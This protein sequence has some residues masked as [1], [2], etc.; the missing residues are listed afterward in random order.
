MAE[1]GVLNEEA[2]GA[3]G[4]RRYVARDDGRGGG[5]WYPDPMGAW[6]ELSIAE[7][8]RGGPSGVAG[9]PFGSSLGRKHYVPAGVPVIRGAQ[10]GG[11]GRFS[12]DGLAFVSSE[13]ADHHLGNLAHPG[14]V[15][16]TQRGTLGQIGLIPSG[17]LYERFLLSQ[18]QMKIS[19]DPAIADSEF[20][21]FA[22]CAPAT[23]QRLVDRAMTA[24]V[25]HI[26]LATLRNFPVSVPDVRKQRRVAAV[27]SAFDELIEINERRIELLED[28]ARSLYREWF[29][30]FRFPGHEEVEL[31]D[32]ELGPI[33]EGWVVTRLDNLVDVVVE[34]VHPSDLDPDSRYVGLE[35]IPRRRTTLRDWGSVESVTSRK[36]SFSVGDTLFGKIRPYFHKVAWAPFNG[37][38]SSDTIVLRAHPDTGLPALVN[39]I[40]SSDELVGQAVATSNGTKMPRA[41]SNALL[42]YKLALPCED[43]LLEFERTVRRWVEWSAAL[44]EHN[45][46]LAATRD[47]LLPRLVTGRLDISDLD[48]GVLT[49][50]EAE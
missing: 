21:Y 10:L 11:G 36:L 45:H 35:H 26:N 50:T 1:Q 14:D 3:R 8:S 2:G 49:P 20:L 39:T 48:L 37:V 34:G 28:L 41:D 13:K 29:V 18:S 33:P 44:V 4:Q 38:A 5:D 32:S 31:V 24:G 47:L 7:L 17:Q 16:V 12:L 6:R 15:I 27:L 25:P 30:R 23:K 22:L 40:A 42:A 46:Q 43:L 19:V 9:G